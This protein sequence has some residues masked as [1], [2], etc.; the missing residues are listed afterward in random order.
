MTARQFTKA[1]TIVSSNEF[2]PQRV[3]LG[4]MSYSDDLPGFE[5]A[6]ETKHI[7]LCSAND[8][9]IKRRGGDD[10]VDYWKTLTG[11][12][13][14]VVE[15]DGAFDARE[16]LSQLVLGN[17]TA[18]DR[19]R[20]MSA[21][22][23]IV[24]PFSP[25]ATELAVSENLKMP[26][27][28]KPRAW[29]V[30]GRKSSLLALA[31]KAGVSTPD[32][33]RLDQDFGAAELFETCLILKKLGYAG[34][35]LK[36]DLGIAGRGHWKFGLEAFDRAAAETLTAR[37]RQE[38]ARAGHYVKSSFVLEGWVEDAVS[39]GCYLD[40]LEDGGVRPIWYWQQLFEPGGTA[41]LGA[42]SITL[43]ADAEEALLD[44]LHT[45]GAA[46]G[47]EGFHGSF[48]PDFL[49]REDTGFKLLEVNARLPATAFAF[50]AAEKLGRDVGKGFFLKH[51]YLKEPMSFLE[52]RDALD[53]LG[54]LLTGGN[55]GR[56]GVLALNYGL[57]PF[58]E[59]ELLALGPSNE[60]CR[61]ALH[62]IQ[63]ALCR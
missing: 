33:H 9:Y 47:A 44:E 7:H 27:W 51:L 22:K 29:D 20:Q 19:I 37:I 25:S 39:I 5:H 35:I 24:V 53:G 62:T 6:Y 63:T 1:S 30:V 21:G 34:A 32:S 60:D 54:L 10:Y 11:E 52:L 14:T 17:G 23:A 58:G 13:F 31:R 2:Y 56:T 49:W 3:L 18:L 8:I 61:Q 28:G 45:L 43:P 55:D 12:D 40:V 4:A 15:L 57:L 46:L 50:H 26:L 42:Q 38:E 36:S 16:T 41:Y 48:G 59:I